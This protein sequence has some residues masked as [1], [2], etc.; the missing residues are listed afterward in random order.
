MHLGP[1]VDTHAPGP[2]GGGGH[3]TSSA[4]GSTAGAAPDLFH[5]EP[6][7]PLVGQC[8]EDGVSH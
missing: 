4:W 5:Q 1:G 6:L 3:L 2:W 8:V 7:K